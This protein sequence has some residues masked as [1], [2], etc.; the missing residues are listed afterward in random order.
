M[1]SVSLGASSTYLSPFINGTRNL[2]KKAADAAAAA[3]AACFFFLS[4]L[5]LF[6]ICFVGRRAVRVG[7]AHLFVLDC[8]VLYFGCGDRRKIPACCCKGAIF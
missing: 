8:S 7:I 5:F 3:A 1:I 4:F 2:Y 6:R